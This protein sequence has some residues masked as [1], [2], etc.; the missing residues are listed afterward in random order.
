MGLTAADNDKL[1]LARQLFV[2]FEGRD[3]ESVVA[4]LHPDVRAHP[5]ISGGPQLVGRDAVTEWWRDLQ[6]DEEFEVRPLDFEERGDCVIVRG[7]IRHREGR[8]LAENQTFWL[9]AFRDGMIDRM[10]SHPTRDA[11]LAA[12]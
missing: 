5:A 6:V 2:W 4:A 7:Y 3:M 11:A 12:C 1:E 8:T 10:E 9:F